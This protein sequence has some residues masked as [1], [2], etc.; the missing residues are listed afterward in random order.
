MNRK[1]IFIILSLI[2]LLPS[3]TMM[4]QYD[5]VSN[6]DGSQS[7][8]SNG[9]KSSAARDSTKN[10]EIPKGIYVW[11]VDERFGDRTP[12][13]PDTLSYLR[14]NHVYSEGVNGEYNTIGNNGMPRL[15]RIFIDR[16]EASPFLFTNGYSQFLV[17]PK[18][19]HFTNTYS[20]ITNFE[21][22]ECGDKT[23]GEDRLKALFAVNINKQ[24]GVGFKFDYLY[25]RGYYA[26]QNTSHFNFSIWASHL[27]ERYQAHLLMSTN[28]QKQSE[29]GGITNDNYILH[30][31]L[32][33]ESYMES[34]IPTTLQS[35]WNRH[36]NHHIFFA[37]RYNI[38][39]YRKVP[40]TEKEIEARKF[41]IASQKEKEEREKQAEKNREKQ[42]EQM[43]DFRKRNKERQQKDEGPKGRPDNARIMGDEPGRE[44]QQT[45]TTRIA[46][47][48]QQAKDS[49]AASAEKKPE[50]EFMKNEYVPVT[51]IFHTLKLDHYRRTYLANV[52]PTGYYLNDYYTDATSDSIKDRTRLTTIKNTFGLS[53][54]EGFNKW[55]KAGMKLF[56]ADDMKHYSLPQFDS[57]FYSW[58]ENSVSIGAEL[59]KRAGNTLHFGALGEFYVLGTD[60]GQVKID[61]NLDLKF[62]L[63]GDTI[64]LDASGYFHLV[65]PMTYYRIYQ[66]RHFK[67]D[68]R[69]NFTKE[70]RT[71]IEGN[72]SLKRTETRLRVA[73]DNITNYTYLGT[74]YTRDSL[75]NQLSTTLT[76]RQASSVQVFTAQLYQN[77]HVGILH[78]DNIIT[79]QKSSDDVVMP[80]PKL[81]I[82]S[83]LYL[84]FKIAK[85]LATDFGADV[86]YFTEYNA[87][88][89]SPAMQSFVIQEN[90]NIR[91][92]VGNYPFVN[93]YANFQLKSC[94][95]FIMMSH[96]NCSSKGNYFLTPHYPTNGRTLRFGLN[97]TFNN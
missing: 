73:V 41:A 67:W 71:H 91:T 74:S 37:H 83:N 54:L 53:L 59:S 46:L 85:V 57:S 24:T 65:Q 49:I 19:F 52:T 26:N 18:D 38:G 80:L 15:N 10:K 61:G 9:R 79:F 36:D 8:S 1:L 55:A 31:E 76:P 23:N 69:D 11:T 72:L 40:M 47:T 6:E 56:I 96:V 89:Y 34:E 20:P 27:G 29:N 30:P 92:K 84:R 22:N 39:F 64:Q 86:R 88:E 90:E 42:E 7:F 78:W 63:L 45:D 77:L 48:A 50:E 3:T 32:Y 13:I 60:V 12:A 66:S 51:S 94:R 28:H 16:G 21:Y 82:Y 93:V 35:N 75:N 44:P 81:N 68:T 87:P 58:T 70:T 5:T 33:T 97:W 95:F 62:P 43:S 17:Q 2:L 14:M 25:S 4:A